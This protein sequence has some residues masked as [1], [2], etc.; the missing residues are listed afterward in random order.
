MKNCIIKL[1]IL[2]RSQAHG[3]NKFK[4]NHKQWNKYQGPRWNNNLYMYLFI[5][6]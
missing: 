5:D 4:R 2:I 1:L 6:L 3:W